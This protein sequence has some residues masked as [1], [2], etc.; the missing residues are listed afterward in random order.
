LGWYVSAALAYHKAFELS[1]EPDDPELHAKLG[2]VYGRLDMDEK[3]LRHYRIAYEKNKS[4]EIGIGLAFAE[5]IMGNIDEFR[6][7]WA[8][9]KRVESDVPSELQQNLNNLDLLYLTTFEQMSVDNP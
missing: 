6:N 7:V 9:L 8:Q 4:P 2:W 1:D 5:H 3:S